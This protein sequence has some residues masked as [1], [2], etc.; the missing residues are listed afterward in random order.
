MQY[1]ALEINVTMGC[2]FYKHPIKLAGLLEQKNL[3]SERLRIKHLLLKM[4]HREL[5]ISNRSKFYKINA[6]TKESCIQASIKI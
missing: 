3:N 2:L 1:Q 5:R 6:I 4:V